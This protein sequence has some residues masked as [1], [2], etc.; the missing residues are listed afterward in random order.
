MAR[1][2]SEEEMEALIDE[3]GN[4][5]LLPPGYIIKISKN[6][7]PYIS[8]IPGAP[9]LPGDKVIKISKNLKPFL[10]RVTRYGETQR[11]FAEKYGRTVGGCVKANVREGMS[12][13]EVHDI[14][15]KCSQNSNYKY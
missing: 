11:V 14:V 4:L 7:K 8:R 9:L 3:D 13:A 5:A 10:S 6:M 1:I 2:L 12:G 15:K